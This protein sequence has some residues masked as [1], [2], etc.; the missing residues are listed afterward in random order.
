MVIDFAL[1]L[2]QQLADG[3]RDAVDEFAQ[4]AEQR[5]HND[6]RSACNSFRR[7]VTPSP[8]PLKT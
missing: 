7:T 3:H 4:H 8:A 2:L 5:P 1:Q 6:Y